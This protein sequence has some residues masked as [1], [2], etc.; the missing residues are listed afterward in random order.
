MIKAPWR[1]VAG[2]KRRPSFSQSEGHRYCESYTHW[3]IFS[4]SRLPFGHGVYHAHGLLVEVGVN[5][6]DY[7]SVNDRTVR[8][9]HKLYG[10]TTLDTLFLTDGRILNILLEKLH[11]FDH[12][13]RELR[14]LLY[15]VISVY[16]N[17]TWYFC[18]HSRLVKEFVLLHLQC[19]IAFR[20]VL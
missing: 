11:Q 16:L 12:T 1:R 6:V 4:Y 9:Y 17:S 10:N 8:V 18:H 2:K 5:G 14:R 7:L 3:F 19:F 20:E 15:Y 13:T